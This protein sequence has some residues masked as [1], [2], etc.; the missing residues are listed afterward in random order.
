MT[1]NEV[2]I[3]LYAYATGEAIRELTA[4]ETSA[5]LAMIQGDSSHTGAVDGQQFGHPGLTVYAI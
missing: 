1:T 4:A 3:T 5:Y 2:T